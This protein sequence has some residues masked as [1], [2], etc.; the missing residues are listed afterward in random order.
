[1]DRLV[2]F[3]SATPITTGLSQVTTLPL[4]NF[5]QLICVDNWF[6]A[7]NE[8]DV[9]TVYDP[10]EGIAAGG[11]FLASDIQPNNQTRSDARRTYYD[12][13]FGRKNYNVLQNS[14]ATR[15]LFDT[16]GPKSPSYSDLVNDSQS[17]IGHLSKTQQSP[18]I[19]KVRHVEER[20]QDTPIPLHATGV[21]V[22]LPLLVTELSDQY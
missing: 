5:L 22:S 20:Q 2:Q 15:I 8:L 18:K 1:M 12:P 14:H 7:L 6:R 3:L 19:H 10:D 9:P 17:N 16:S 21:E 11:Y 4:S 13:F